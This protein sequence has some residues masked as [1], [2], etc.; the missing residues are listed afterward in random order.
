MGFFIVGLNLK[1]NLNKSLENCNA[2]SFVVSLSITLMDKISQFFLSLS[3][4]T[5]YEPSCSF[6]QKMSQISEKISRLKVYQKN[7]FVQLIRQLLFG[8]L[9][10]LD[11]VVQVCRWGHSSV[12]ELSLRDLVVKNLLLGL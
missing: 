3:Y 10:A 2:L 6:L 5:Y 11:M 8:F 9:Q 12:N 7:D 4:M 1:K